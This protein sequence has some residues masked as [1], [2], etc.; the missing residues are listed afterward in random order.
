MLNENVVFKLC[1]ILYL[2]VFGFILVDSLSLMMGCLVWG[3]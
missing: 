3:S 1:D 2:Y